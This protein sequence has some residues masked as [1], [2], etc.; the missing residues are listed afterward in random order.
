VPSSPIQSS[1]P[2]SARMNPPHL[3]EGS[4]LSNV[5]HYYPLHQP[6]FAWIH[7]ARPPSRGPHDYNGAAINFGRVGPNRSSLGKGP[8]PSCLRVIKSVI[9][10]NHSRRSRSGV[11]FCIGLLQLMFPVDVRAQRGKEVPKANYGLAIEDWMLH[12]ED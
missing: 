12:I 8:F 10:S 5:I 2:S 3:R 1:P 7:L 6:I 9:Q 11:Q 4:L